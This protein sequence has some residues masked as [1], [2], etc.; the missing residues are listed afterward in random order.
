VQGA[1]EDGLGA[2]SGHPDGVGDLLGLGVRPDHVRLRFLTDLRIPPTSHQAERDLRP[3][4]PAEDL[5]PPPLGTAARHRYAISGYLSTAAKPGKDII[6]AIRD[7]LAGTLRC[8][9][10]RTRHNPAHRQSRNAFSW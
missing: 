10:S 8:R 7:A 3:A 1:G 2:V 5:R 6:I 4:N 9:P